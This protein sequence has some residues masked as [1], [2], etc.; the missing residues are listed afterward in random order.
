[1][2]LPDITFVYGLF[3]QGVVFG[4]GLGAVVWLIG[5]AISSIYNLIKRS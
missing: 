1:M 2:D 5:Y 4:A 3:S